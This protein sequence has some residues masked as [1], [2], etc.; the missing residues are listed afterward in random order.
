MAGPVM[1]GA[2]PQRRI[3][4]LPDPHEPKDVT[5]DEDETVRPSPFLA[6]LSREI[7]MS[8]LLP[9]HAQPIIT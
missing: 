6:S 4:R 8:R 5:A 9:H 7:V 3:E 2:V 1:E